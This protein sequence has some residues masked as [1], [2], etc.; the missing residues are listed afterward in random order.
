MDLEIGAGGDVG[1]TPSTLHSKHVFLGFGDV[2]QVDDHI[3]VHDLLDGGVFPDGEQF[4][5]ADQPLEFLG[6]VSIPHQL[7]IRVEV[8]KP[9][10]LVVDHP[11]ND[12]NVLIAV[13]RVPQV[14]VEILSLQLAGQLI[15][16][17]LL[18]E[19]LRPLVLADACH[20]VVSL[21]GHRLVGGLLEGYLVAKE[22]S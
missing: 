18:V 7:H 14:V 4:P 8:L 6:E 2:D 16:E 5:D 21:L 9:G 13:W 10:L 22:A 12:R 15:Y 11:V 17:P 3:C 20:E 1:K 19:S